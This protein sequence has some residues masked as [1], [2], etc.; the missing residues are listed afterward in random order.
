MAAKLFQL[1]PAL[2]QWAGGCKATGQSLTEGSKTI[3]LSNEGHFSLQC[4]YFYPNLIAS[5]CRL[6]VAVFNLTKILCLQVCPQQLKDRDAAALNWD[7]KLLLQEDNLSLK[8]LFL[9]RHCS[10]KTTLRSSYLK[11][12]IHSSSCL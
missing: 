9:P 10:P 8:M 6:N 4:L 11:I 5:C 3:L 1:L 7:S 2:E 12:F